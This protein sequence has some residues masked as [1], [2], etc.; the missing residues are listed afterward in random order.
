MIITLLYLIHLSL[1][2]LQSQQSQQRL[3]SVI[4]PALSALLGMALGA[5]IS[6]IFG[7]KGKKLD[8]NSEFTKRILERLEKVEKIAADCIESESHKSKRL[9][10]IASKAQSLYLEH[11]FVLRECPDVAKVVKQLRE[12]TDKSPFDDPVLREEIK[13]IYDEGQK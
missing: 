13:K 11:E 9:F 5:A 1:Y 8:Q 10:R 6:G 3:S 12:I 4:I 2:W 7:F